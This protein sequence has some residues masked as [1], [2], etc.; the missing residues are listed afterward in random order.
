MSETARFDQI[1]A[2][3]TVLADALAKIPL[4]SL[5]PFRRRRIGCRAER[6]AGS[7]NLRSIGYGIWNRDRRVTAALLRATNCP[8]SLDLKMGQSFTTGINAALGYPHQRGSAVG[9]RVK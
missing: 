2:D 5:G 7:S 1:A 3:F 8:F 4:D 9:T 6:L